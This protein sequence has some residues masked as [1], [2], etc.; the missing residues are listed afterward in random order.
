M[1]F[2]QVSQSPREA[3]GPLM[4]TFGQPKSWRAQPAEYSFTRVASI[5]HTWATSKPCGKPFSRTPATRISLSPSCGLCAMAMSR[6]RWAKVRTPNSWSSLVRRGA[7]FGGN[8]RTCRPGSGRLR[9][10]KTNSST[11][12]KSLKAGPRKSP[13]GRSGLGYLD[14]IPCPMAIGTHPTSAGAAKKAWSRTFPAPLRSLT[15]VR[16][17]DWR[18]GKEVMEA[19]KVSSPLFDSLKSHLWCLL[20]LHSRSPAAGPRR[21]SSR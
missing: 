13:I 12:K 21:R 9:A 16:T 8:M 3:K 20:T 4:R 11:S 1:A 18:P 14:Q 2:T 6:K 7:D 17:K 15:P 19:L 5:H 10:T